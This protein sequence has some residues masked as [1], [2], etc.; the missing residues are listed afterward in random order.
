MLENMKIAIIVAGVLS[1]GLSLIVFLLLQFLRRQDERVKLIMKTLYLNT[2]G[3]KTIGEKAEMIFLEQQNGFDSQRKSFDHQR[4]LVSSLN[5][6]LKHIEAALFSDGNLD[7]TG[8]GQ[9]N[10][11]NP[12]VPTENVI[13][14]SSS[15][16]S[17]NTKTPHNGE[18]MSDDIARRKGV[19]LLK[20]L[21]QEKRMRPGETSE[22]LLQEKRMRP[23][24]TSESL[25]Q[26]KR[27]RPGET[28][29][30]LLQEKRMRP[31]ETSES[32]LREKRMRSGDASESFL[33]GKLVLS[34]EASEALEKADKLTAMFEKNFKIKDAPRRALNG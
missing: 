12:R 15:M 22:S 7:P 17:G 31:G 19:I 11:Q 26:E 14:I 5:R 1:V 16:I 9:V 6:Q 4:V 25:L 23:G 28:S 21:L 18:M 27:M 30:S 3:I 10:L 13:G 24:E 2:K 20:S 8:G 33:Q 34:K 32:L 29:E